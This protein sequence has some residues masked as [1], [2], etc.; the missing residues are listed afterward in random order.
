M[1]NIEKVEAC[2]FNNF[3]NL[4]VVLGNTVEIDKNGFDDCVTLY[5]FNS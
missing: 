3:K 1:P 2:Q 4:R 5:K